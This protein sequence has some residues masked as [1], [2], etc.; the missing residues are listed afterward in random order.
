MKSENTILVGWGGIKMILVLGGRGFIG[1]NLVRRLAKTEKLR[2]FDKTW[3][4]EIEIENVEPITGDFQHTDF[5]D[6][7][8]GVDTVFHFISTSTPFD[9]TNDMLADIEKNILPT[10]RLLD[11]MRKNSVKKIFFASSGGTVYGECVK[12]AKENERISPECVY[13]AQKAWIE[14]CL[15]L[16]E[17][18]DGIQGYIL[19]IGNPYGWEINKN[20]RQGIIP[21]YTEKIVKGESIEIWGTGENKRD[22]IYIDEVIDA[23]E[24]VYFYKGPYR[25]FNIGTGSSY[26]THEM[27][28]QIERVVGKK[29]QIVY[30]EKRKCDLLESQLDVS[31]INR[32]C[33][34]RSR[35]T[36]EQ[37]IEMYINKLSEQYAGF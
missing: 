3:E 32:E 13:A 15:H 11:A 19:R 6:M 37:G 8:K 26:S 17:K 23:I 25:I 29:A 33:G 20:K 2:V 14:T 5:E 28:E 18:Y 16:Y 35:L 7:L 24:A 27:I 22:Y 31:L 36:V 12:P 4:P 9:G 1:L 21:I 10:I 30:L 34:W